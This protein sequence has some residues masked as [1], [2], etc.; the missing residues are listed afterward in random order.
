MKIYNLSKYF[1]RFLVLQTTITTITIWY[2]DNYLIGD[3]ADG[4][5]KIKDNL[6]EDRN[7]FYPFV[8]NDFI[9]IDIFVCK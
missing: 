5:V 7:R 3:Y 4:F 8:T 2:F 6:F 1:L 9:K